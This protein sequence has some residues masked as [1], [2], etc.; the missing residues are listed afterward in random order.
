MRTNPVATN[1]MLRAQSIATRTGFLGMGLAAAILALPG[2]TRATENLPGDAGR[3]K[4]LFEKRCTGCHGLD[5]DK[6]GPRLRAV[7]GRR[8]GSVAT[9]QYSDALRTAHITWD[10]AALDHWLTDTE[11]V[12]PKNDMA[13]RV[14]S[15]EERADIIAFLRSTTQSGQ[16]P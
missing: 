1:P 15:A 7:Y 5:Q 3:G 2:A 4:S 11:A 16:Q 12:I 14:P 8:A 6:E 10:D 13:F 9:F